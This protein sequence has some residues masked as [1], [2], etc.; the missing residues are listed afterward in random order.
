M[1]ASTSLRTHDLPH[2]LQ[3]P[4]AYSVFGVYEDKE[5]DIPRLVKLYNPHGC[6]PWTGPWSPSWLQKNQMYEEA[7]ILKCVPGE[8]YM[9][10]TSFM[11]Y[12]SSLTFCYSL[13]P[14]FS[15]SDCSGTWTPSNKRVEF[16][17][18]L[19][20]DGET[21]VALS[22][23]GRRQMRDEKESMETQLNIRLSIFLIHDFG[24]I[25]KF[26]SGW[27]KLRTRTYHE[28]SLKRGCYRVVGEC[29][30]LKEP[31]QCVYLRVAS[32]T[33]IKLLRKKNH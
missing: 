8:F 2:G 23:T 29:G 1:N 3:G 10:Y 18:K 6:D 11:K 25:D 22:Q 24:D 12:F 21:F 27:E 16:I 14:S 17:L 5:R 19:E 20:R 7:E 28:R 33:K 31:S 13:G 15:E 9:P 26:N 4:H 30:D 32:N